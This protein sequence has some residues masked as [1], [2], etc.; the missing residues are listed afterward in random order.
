MI[1]TDINNLTLESHKQVLITC[2]YQVSDK[3][4]TKY[5]RQY[6]DARKTREKNSGTDICIYCSRYLKFSGRNNPNCK[7][8]NLDDSLMSQIDTPFKAWL[9]GWIASD[10]S[11]AKKGET[12]IAILTSDSYLL[13]EITRLVNGP[14][15]KL[16]KN[17]YMSLLSISS[18]QLADDCRRHLGILSPMKKSKI[19]S[20]PSL[21]EILIPHFIRGL[22]EGDGY[23]S[24]CKKYWKSGF[25]IYPRLGIASISPSIKEGLKAFYGF[26]S[27]T[28]SGWTTS[29]KKAI[30][31]AS[32]IYQN[33]YLTPILKR[34]YEIYQQ[35]IL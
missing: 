22:L 9:L 34:K 28:K 20:F 21:P 13:E 8:K 26:G 4:S 32:N 31:V 3:C 2:D 5:S 35:W 6:R 17:N 7:Y 11:L 18:I 25:G 30:Q 12:N 29:N 16:I 27:I 23:L 10:G 14:K 19:V 33:A 1:H 24:H 15:I